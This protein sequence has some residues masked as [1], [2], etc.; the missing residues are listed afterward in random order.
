MW[1]GPSSLSCHVSFFRSVQRYKRCRCS[2]C[3]RERIP[4][5]ADQ[6]F[7]LRPD[8]GFSN[9]C[10][11][12]TCCE[13][14]EESFARKRSESLRNCVS[15]V[16]KFPSAVWAME[17]CWCRLRPPRGRKDFSKISALRMPISPGPIKVSS[18]RSLNS[19]DDLPSS[20]ATQRP[21]PCPRL[22]SRHPQ[23]PGIPASEW[24]AT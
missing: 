6:A 19:P 18:Q 12:P 22:D 3:F 2:R 7:R 15:K 20:S 9:Q 13:L 5:S 10:A 17:C 1:I 24:L 4:R 11:F 14:N 21:S 8:A 16:G 23:H